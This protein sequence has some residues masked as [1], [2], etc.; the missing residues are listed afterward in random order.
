MGLF[1]QVING[2]V[3]A[4]HVALGK[5]AAK[6]LPGF[7]GIP[8]AGPTGMIMQ[9]G[10]AIVIGWVGANFVSANAG[11][12]WLAGALA[13]PVEDMIKQLN[14]PFISPLLGEEDIVEIGQ[15]PGSGELVGA[16]PQVPEMVG[17]YAHDYAINQQQ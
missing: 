12:M 3:D 16:Y 5:V 10:V 2:V 9:A 13:A 14:I 1:N 8:T 17:D 15:Y 4:G 7:V 6:S 11:K